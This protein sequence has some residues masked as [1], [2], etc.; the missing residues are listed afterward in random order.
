MKPKASDKKK[1]LV[2]FYDTPERGSKWC[3]KAT[4]VYIENGARVVV[5]IP[6][7]R[8]INS[9]NISIGKKIG[10]VSFNRAMN[11]EGKTVKD[12]DSLFKHVKFLCLQAHQTVVGKIEACEPKDPSLSQS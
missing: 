5:V 7:D 12:Q 1:P 8:T 10:L 2:L 9:C 11:V 3:P 4:V 6:L